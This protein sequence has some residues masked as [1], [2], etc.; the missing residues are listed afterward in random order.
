MEEPSS[1]SVSL[2]KSGHFLL[3][4]E[5]AMTWV[6]FCNGN[7][8]RTIGPS[9]T[10]LCLGFSLSPW[11]A[12]ITSWIDWKLPFMWIAT[13][14]RYVYTL[15]EQWGKS[16]WRRK[17]RTRREEKC[18]QTKKGMLKQQTR[19]NCVFVLF[20]AGLNSAS[21]GFPCRNLSS[22]VSRSQRNTHIPCECKI[23]KSWAN[24]DGPIG[25]SPKAFL[26]TER[27]PP[28]ESRAWILTENCICP[29]VR[30]QF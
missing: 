7:V 28:G 21:K 29:E 12:L 10:S 16:A 22:C 11:Q 24:S 17:K 13:G 14:W 18:T 4:L 26:K 6:H 9:D 23:M 20:P 8:F 25:P 19:N 15:P 3:P 1:R 2:Y 27:W 30:K 5:G